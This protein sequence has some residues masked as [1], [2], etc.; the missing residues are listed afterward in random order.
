MIKRY[1]ALFFILL[2]SIV[3]LVPAVIPH[4]HHKSEVCIEDTHCQTD[5]DKHQ[6]AEGN[7]EHDGES[8]FDN[9]VLSRVFVIPFNKTTHKRNFFN[10]TDSN[11]QLK[12]FHADLIAKKYYSLYPIIISK[13]QFPVLS[14]DYTSISGSIIGLRAPPIV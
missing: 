1:T 3:L 10:Y 8:N 11:S 2:A 5:N 14:Y 13:A 9:C 6:A 4:H 12:S 7:H